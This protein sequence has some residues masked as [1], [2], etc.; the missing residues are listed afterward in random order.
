MKCTA[1]QTLFPQNISIFWEI[2][3]NE[4]TVR[5]PFITFKAIS[6]IHLDQLRSISGDVSMT[7]IANNEILGSKWT[8]LSKDFL[9]IYVWDEAFL[10]KCFLCCLLSN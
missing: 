10:L 7:K 6:M 4:L 8:Y 1:L 2:V 3:K 5:F 9:T